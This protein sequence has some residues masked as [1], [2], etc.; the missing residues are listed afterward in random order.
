[1][2]LISGKARH[3]KDTLAGFLKEYLEKRNKRV[4]VAHYGD[5]VKYI[6]RT[7]FDWDGVKDEKGRDLL[8]RVGTDTIR[9]EDP[10]F[11]AWFIYQVLRFFPDAW[12]YVLIPDC[13][14]PNEITTPLDYGFGTYYLRVV[15]PNFDNG[16]TP[17][18]QEH[19][20]ETALDDVKP[21]FTFINNGSLED[22]RGLAYS[23][24]ECRL[25]DE[26]EARL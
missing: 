20:S 5:L 16:L 2:V 24:A 17:A 26:A 19:P 9:K 18:Q 15:R 10:D 3:G 6:C 8:Q 1:M 25:F 4:L 12:D 11:W 7:F 13:R 22:L 23:W 21:D 14:F